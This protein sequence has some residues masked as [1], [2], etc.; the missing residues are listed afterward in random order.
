MRAPWQSFRETLR[1]ALRSRRNLV[2]FQRV[3]HL[4]PEPLASPEDV[5]GFL[6]S[7]EGDRVARDRLL[8]ALISMARG[9]G[10]EADLGL[11]MVTLG[12]WRDLDLI[13]RRWQ[14]AFPGD[15]DEVVSMIRAAFTTTILR[16]DLD[17]SRNPEASLSLSTERA[18][19]EWWSGERRRRQTMASSWDE[20]TGLPDP[21][22][23]GRG[24]AA[25]F[26]SATSLRSRLEALDRVAREAAGPDVD[27]VYAVD[28]LGHDLPEVAASLGIGREA[29]KKRY[30]RAK[31]RMAQALRRAGLDPCPRRP[32]AP[33]TTGCEGDESPGGRG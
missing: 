32:V 1:S 29:A 23:A 4:L 20:T 19:K 2:R 22:S 10:A 31:A 16:M 9:G 28:L 15:P 26:P 27:V 5:V 7:R 24:T 17:R 12:R 18:L 8:R 13:H 25:G 14:R 3:R 11:A 21:E 33:A 6:A 30:Q